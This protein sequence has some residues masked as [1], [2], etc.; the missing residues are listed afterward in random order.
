MRGAR[1]IIIDV[2]IRL[3]LSIE[4]FELGFKINV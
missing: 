4:L 1:L 3:Q 2:K